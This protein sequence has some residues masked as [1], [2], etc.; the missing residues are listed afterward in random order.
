MKLI[1]RDIK[2]EFSL[3]ASEYPIVTILGPRQSGKT[4]FSKMLCPDKPYCSLENPDICEFAL[5]DPRGF[6]KKY[7]SGAVLDEIQRAPVLLSYLQQIVDG[8]MTNGSFILTGSHQLG[9]HNNITQS[10]AGRT[11]LLTLYPYS[12]NEIEKSNSI[13]CNGTFDLICK[14]FYPGIHSKSIRTA[15][16]HRNYIKTYFERDV[17]ELINLKDLTL[18]QKFLKLLAGRIGQL[19]NHSNLA[20]DIGVSSTTIKNWLSILSASFL[21]YELPPYFINSRKRLVKTSKI[22]FTD[23]GVAAFLLGIKNGE[24]LERDPLR[25]AIFENAVV[26]EVVKGLN[27]YG[28]DESLYFYRDSNNNEV[29]LVLDSGNF[30]FPIE[31]KS[32]ETYNKSFLKGIN[33]FFA[34]YKDLTKNGLVV[35]NGEYEQ[36][37]GNVEIINY[38]KFFDKLMSIISQG[39]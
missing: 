24:Q 21:I 30:L 8:G 25:G 17:R 39:D 2:E 29:D 38:L 34:D 1:T 22:Y 28:L 15:S 4:T 13:P 6:L 9:L 10:L 5:S 3:L 20:N 33:C 32:S 37:V 7:K 36:C 12:L 27:N 18:F 11:G 23:T 19:V 16:F 35:Y 31:I 14:G 26:M